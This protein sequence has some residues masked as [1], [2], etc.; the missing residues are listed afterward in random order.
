[1]NKADDKLADHRGG[2][3]EVERLAS[4]V[5]DGGVVGDG[6]ADRGHD[7]NERMTNDE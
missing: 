1:M 3:V 2:V 4:D 7:V 5:A 6:L